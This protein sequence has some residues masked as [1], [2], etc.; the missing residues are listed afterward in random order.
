M[1]GGAGPRTTEMDTFSGRRRGHMVCTVSAPM[2][3]RL[4][5]LF[6]EQRLLAFALRF[7]LGLPREEVVRHPGP[8]TEALENPL[9]RG[10]AARKRVFF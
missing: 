3:H 5:P 4:R 2:L 6:V 8:A 1:S 10:L 9:Q 7:D